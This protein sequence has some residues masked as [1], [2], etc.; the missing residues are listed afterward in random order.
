MQT[1]RGL[2]FITWPRHAQWSAAFMS[3]DIIMNAVPSYQ[4][5]T[6]MDSCRRWL[7]RDQSR[8]QRYST[9]LLSLL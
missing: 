2:H 3:T 9:Y 6:G 4:V 8:L 5:A 1:T 7:Q